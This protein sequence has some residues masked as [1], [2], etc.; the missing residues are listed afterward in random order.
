LVQVIGDFFRVIAG[1][2]PI[3]PGNEN[4][5]RS[6]GWLHIETGTP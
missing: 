6:I 4:Q 2:G 1:I 3:R 5:E